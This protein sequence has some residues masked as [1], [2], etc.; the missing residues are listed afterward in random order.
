MQ[1]IYN[2]IPET[3]RVSTSYNVPTVVAVYATR[4]APPH[5]KLQYFHIS[6]IRGMCPV[7]N[8]A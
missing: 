5:V 4:N 2:Y 6:T 8:M 3:T 7:P 1:D